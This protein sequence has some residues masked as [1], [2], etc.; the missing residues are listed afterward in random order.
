MDIQGAGDF[1]DPMGVFLEIA[2]RGGTKG[3]G[4]GWGH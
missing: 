3:Y 2:S 4:L 1:H